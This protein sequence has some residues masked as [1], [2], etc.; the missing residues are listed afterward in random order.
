MTIS[1]SHDALYKSIKSGKTIK[2][3]FCSY[4]KK[5]KS[6]IIGHHED[7][8]KPLEVIWLCQQCHMNIYHSLKEVTKKE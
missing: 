8:S 3:D 4:C 6:F 1:K 7:Y 2:P 5:K